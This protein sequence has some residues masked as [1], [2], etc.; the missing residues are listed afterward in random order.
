MLK[1]EKEKCGD[2]YKELYEKY[3]SKVAHL[4]YLNSINDKEQFKQEFIK[5]VVPYYRKNIISLFREI[6]ELYNSSER[7]QWIG[8]VFTQLEASLKDG[9]YPNGEESDSPSE[10]LWSMF[11]KSQHLSTQFESLKEALELIERCIAHTV[12]IP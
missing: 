4:H 1:V 8:E 2:F 6:R 5:F 3:K 7:A 9:K 12:T 11:L 10:Y